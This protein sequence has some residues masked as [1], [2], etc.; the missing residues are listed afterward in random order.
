[1]RAGKDGCPANV[2]RERHLNTPRPFLQAPFDY[3]PFD[4]AQG[5]QGRAASTPPPA[6]RF[7]RPSRRRGG[8]SGF[9]QV[10]ERAIVGDGVAFAF[11]R[12]DRFVLDDGDLHATAH[13]A[14]RFG[15]RAGGPEEVEG[16][17]RQTVVAPR[18]GGPG[19]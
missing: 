14:L 6:A 18:E 8:G 4:Y 12:A 16:A 15:K 5:R 3:A 2:P 13:G 19:I 7:A 10:D 9:Q 17:A 11:L 1:M